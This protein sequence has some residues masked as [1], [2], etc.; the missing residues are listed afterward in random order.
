MQSLHFSRY[1]LAVFAAV[2]M[3]AGCAASQGQ[4]LGLGAM[5][6]GN[7][8]SATNQDLLYVADF[9]T[10]KVYIYS[11]PRPQLVGTL[12]GFN[13]PW[14]ECVDKNGNV[15][16]TNF[17][18]QSIVE[19]AH[20]G[21]TPIK[22]L[23]DAKGYPA[24]CSVDRVTG[25]L[26]VANAYARRSRSGNVLIFEDA[27]STPTE[28]TSPGLYYYDSAGFDAHGDL[29]VDGTTRNGRFGLVELGRPRKNF[30]TIT[31]NKQVSFPI[32]V[33]WRDAY[34]AIGGAGSGS[35]AHSN[36]L[37]VKVTHGSG[38][39]LDHTKLAGNIGAF[40]VQNSTLVASEDAGLVF[41]RYPKGG[42]PI[43]RIDG[44]D[45]PLGVTVS[46]GR[47]DNGL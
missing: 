19:Y 2:A 16:I 42:S 12:T 15:W 47:P 6:R 18:G 1:A 41:F 39:I 45:Y 28:Y 30:K 10:N 7:G 33:E 32:G 17:V 29:F 31:L 25:D 23:A 43:K 21:A 44:L 38:T 11:Y 27:S 22:T 46:A 5:P 14:A 13:G 8:A 9:G 40:V 26:A 24:A 3:L 35:S 4:T 37:Q 36:V 34:L 20:G